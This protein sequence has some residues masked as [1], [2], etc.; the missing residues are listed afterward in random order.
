MAD[1]GG[2]IKSK[3]EGLRRAFFGPSKEEMK[4]L[5]PEGRISKSKLWISGIAGAYLI[6]LAYTMVKQVMADAEA[7]KNT[8]IMMWAFAVVFAVFGA[9]TLYRVYKIYKS[10]IYFDPDNPYTEP[11]EDPEYMDE[12]AEKYGKEAA[13]CGEDPEYLRRLAEKYAAEE[14][15]EK[16]HP[17]PE[18]DS[19]ENDS[20][21][22]EADSLGGNN[23]ENAGEAA[24]DDQATDK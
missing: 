7:T 24:A 18:D 1:N 9:F 20:A 21:Q 19:A 15:D 14:A 3:T 22:P 6:Y 23:P 17:Q 10:G 2:G 13:E 8:M 4:K 12:L 11:Q 16:Y 5:N